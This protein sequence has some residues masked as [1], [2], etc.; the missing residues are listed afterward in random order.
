M[1]RS[2]ARPLAVLA[3]TALL[4]GA[5]CAFVVDRDQARICR[6]VL[7]ALEASGTRIALSRTAR[8]DGGVRVDYRATPPDGRALPRF[9]VCR[10]G[11]ANDLV[12]ITT[13]RGEVPGARLYLLKRYYIDTPDGIAADPGQASPDADLPD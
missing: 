9:A 13:D 8:A 2:K 3:G 11:P 12:G 5:G 7:P 4:A 10:F 6:V 1:N